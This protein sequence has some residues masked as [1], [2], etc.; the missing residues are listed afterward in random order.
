MSL[1]KTVGIAC[2]GRKVF[3]SFPSACQEECPSK[4]YRFWTPN[5]YLLR[6]SG[7]LGYVDS[8]QGYN[9]YK[10]VRC[11]L[12]RVI[13]LHI[14]SY[15]RYPE[16]LSRWKKKTENWRIYTRIYTHT[17]KFHHVRPRNSLV[18]LPGRI[19]REAEKMATFQLDD[20]NPKSLRHGKNAWV[21]SPFTS[22]HPFS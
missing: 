3:S 12:T 14:T 5:K 16:P 10:W 6:G 4:K 9:L 22:I 13:N 15:I 18:Q 2:V 20:E 7:Y 8:N 17:P 21:T 19:C 11:P 1:S